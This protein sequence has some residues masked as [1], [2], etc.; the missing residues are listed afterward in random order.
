M[1]KSKLDVEK[2]IMQEIFVDLV[3]SL[4]YESNYIPPPPVPFPTLYFETTDQNLKDSIYK[5]DSIDRKQFLTDFQK[6]D[7]EK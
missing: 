1:D 7:V 5:K 6:R 3:D 4:H 2:E